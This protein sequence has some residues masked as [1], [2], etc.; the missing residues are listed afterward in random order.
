MHDTSELEKLGIPTAFVASCE[1][2][3][4]SAAQATALGFSPHP[5][6]VEHPIQDRTDDEM[7]AMADRAFTEIVASIVA[8]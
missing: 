8:S 6:F 1:F 2:E 3:D 4:A 5:I 7:T